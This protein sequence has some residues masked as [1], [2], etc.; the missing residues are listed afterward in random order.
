MIT[1]TRRLQFSAGHRVWGHESKCANLHGHNYVVFIHARA[2]AL[3]SIGRVIDFSVLKEQFA[4]WID[5]FW[6]HGMILNQDDPICHAFGSVETMLRNKLW[7]APFNPTAEE[8]AE[9]LLKEIAPSLMNPFGIE[10]FKITLW[11]TE[12]CY[13]E[14]TLDEK[15]QLRPL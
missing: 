7:R 3:D 12:N 14:A 6:D 9:Y 2:K 4:T 15:H 8:M 10:V 13:A 11:E 1:C 5:K